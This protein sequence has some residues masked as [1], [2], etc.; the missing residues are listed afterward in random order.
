[1]KITRPYR[2]IADCAKGFW[3]KSD[4]LKHESNCKCWT[5]PKNRTCKTCE[6]GQYEEYEADTGYG[7]VWVCGNS[8]NDSDHHKGAGDK[9]DYL[10]AHC[11]HYK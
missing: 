6:F 3:S 2:Y 11:D 1:M 5:N 4:C 10:S 8:D 7:G 9:V